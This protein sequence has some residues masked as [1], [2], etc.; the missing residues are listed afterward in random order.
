[1]EVTN[2]GSAGVTA[3]TGVAPITSSGGATPAI[4][5]TPVTYWQTPNTSANFTQIG[6]AGANQTYASGLI[7]NYP[8]SVGHIAFDVAVLD[9]SANLYDVGL[10]NAAGNL[11]ANVGAASYI[12]TGLFTPALA[13]G[14]VRLN[15]GLY[16]VSLTGNATVMKIFGMA[17]NATQSF[18]WGFSANAGASIGGALPATITPPTPTPPIVTSTQLWLAM[19]T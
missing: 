3:V 2:P 4:G 8:I 19:Y 5:L 17:S 13:Q 16:Y 6:P 9:N 10:Y 11:V 18:V 14:T 15:P 12:T 1:M 7:I